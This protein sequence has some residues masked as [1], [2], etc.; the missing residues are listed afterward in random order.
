MLRGL[1]RRDLAWLPLV[2][3]GLAIIYLPGL[4]YPLLFDDS[5]L[6][7]G[8]LQA[9]YGKL[10]L[11]PRALSYGTFLWLQ[12]MFGEGWWKQRVV[13]LLLHAGVALALWAMWRELLRSIVPM[14]TETGA[15]GAPLDA[16]P[17]LGLG[18][19]I[20][21][22]NPVAVY[23]VQYLI[24]RSIVMATLFVVLGLWLFAQGLRTRRWWMHAAA[25]ACYVAAALSKENAI[26]APLAAVPVYIVVARPPVKR[27]A[28]LAAAGTA[29]IAAVV[30]LLWPRY[31]YMLGAPIDEYSRVYIEQLGKLSPEAKQHAFALSI[32]NE[33]YLFFQYGLRWLLPYEGWMSIAMRPPFPIA[34][35][36]LPQ[37]LGIAGYPAVVAGGFWLLIRYRDWRSLVAISILL[38]ALLFP[39]EFA[40]VWVQDPFVLYRSYL[41]AIGI[42]GLVVFVAHGPSWRVVL[43]VGLVVGILFVWQALDRVLSMESAERVWTDAIEKLP[44]DPRAVGRW[45][46][47]LNRGSEYVDRDR[48]DLAM[49]DFENSAALGDLGMGALNVGTLLAA[50][51]KHAEALKA[52]DEAERQGYS[53]YNIWMQRGLT[54]AALG[55]LDDAQRE[56]AHV[57]RFDP[58]PPPA[59]MGVVLLA[60]GR[61]EMQLGKRDEA[62]GD[63]EHL[64]QLDPKSREGRYLLGI[65]YV[66]KSE[67]QRALPLLDSLV[68]DDPNG[69]S[70]YARALANYGLKRKAEALSDIENAMRL[71]GDNPALREWQAKIR[72]L[73]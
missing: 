37:L 51:G 35:T 4:G 61:V 33:S 71:D 50:Q 47:Y 43:A 73:P 26:L 25:F 44:N 59:A 63:L 8:S 57:K 13:N 67:P 32:L 68:R 41:W 10:A 14:A 64:L 39:T 49:R 53:A 1:L 45:F 54:F 48:F 27:L 56:L 42:P 31:G 9:E 20:F 18:I 3:A 21:A 12:A 52:F 58:P 62:I 2:V 70:Y 69:R 65:A 23:A 6:T 7:D 5:F 46:P 15:P 34:W 30:A 28:I 55:R 72:A 38:P 40:T 19:A 16:S 11:K 29:M 36:T 17:A 22:L 66:M 24:Q 60:L